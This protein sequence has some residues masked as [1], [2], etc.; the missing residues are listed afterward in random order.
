MM[1]IYTAYMYAHRE[2]CK[3]HKAYHTQWGHA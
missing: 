3:S 1:N 2:I